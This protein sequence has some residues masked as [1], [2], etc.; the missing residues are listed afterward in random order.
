V[1]HG[2]G[3]QDAFYD[4]AQVLFFSTH[5]YPFYPGSGDW[6][7]NGAG[8]GRGYT[9]NVPL[10]PGVGDDG[11]RRI[12]DGLLAPL[13]ERFRPQLVLVSAGYDAHWDDPLAGLHL[14]LAGYWQ[15]ARAVVEIAERFC[16]GRLVVVLEGGYNLEVLAH[17]VADTCRALLGDPSPGP[18][19]L[20]P[21]SW[22]ERP[23]DNLLH[24]LRRFHGLGSAL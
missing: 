17:G 14:S 2:N 11:F 13:A 12:Y 24:S 9:V 10:P 20:G 6:G 16:E 1:H 18:D 19:P 4:S 5:E 22:T 23:I 7:E 8:A 3:T 21:C 15:M